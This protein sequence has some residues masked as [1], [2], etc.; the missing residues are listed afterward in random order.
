MKR[1]AELSTHNHLVVRLDQNRGKTAKKTRKTPKYNESITVNPTFLVNP[2][3]CWGYNIQEGQ[4]QGLSEGHSG[5]D[6]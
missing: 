4:I 2:G 6:L 5:S 3:K 1:N